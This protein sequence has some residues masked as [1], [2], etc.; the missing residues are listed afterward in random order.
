MGSTLNLQV[1]VYFIPKLLVEAFV[2]IWVKTPFIRR[3]LT[4]KKVIPLFDNDPVNTATG[5]TVLEQGL[6][7]TE[8]PVMDYFLIRKI[9]LT[10]D[11]QIKLLQ[12]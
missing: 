1:M 8:D 11:L 3:E 4:P 12:S 10:K 7:A 5:K 2:Q 6:L 9:L